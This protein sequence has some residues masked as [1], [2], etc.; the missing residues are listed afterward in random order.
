MDI[1]PSVRENVKLLWFALFILFFVFGCERKPTPRTEPIGPLMMQPAPIPVDLIGRLLPVLAQVESAGDIRAIGDSGRAVGLFQ[2][3]PIYVDDC[4]RIAGTNY[5]L[6][7]RYDPGKSAAMVRIYLSHYDK[8]AKADNDIDRMV[9]LSRIH[10]GGPDGHKKKC[11]YDRGEKVR[12][13][14]NERKRY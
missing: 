14:L 8:R 10:H 7:D 13:L 6:E 4:N 12:R 5:V 11:T 2:I 1:M 3:W 9:L